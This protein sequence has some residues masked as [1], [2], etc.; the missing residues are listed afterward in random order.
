MY[1]LQSYVS[2]RWESGTGTPRPLLNPATEEQVAETTTEGIDF[3]AALTYARDVGGP[4]LRAL[5]F[6]QRGETLKAMSRAL[7]EHREELIALEALNNGA[8]RGD[9]KF[10]VDGATGTLA[11]YARQGRQLGD[12]RWQICGESEKLS[13]GARFIGQHVRLPRPGVA[14]HVNAFNFPGWGTFEKVAVALLSGMP[15]VSK[16]A[17]ATALTAWRMAQIIVEADILPEGAFSFVAGSTGDLLDHLGPQD[18]VA[19]TGSAQTGAWFRNLPAVREL[20]TRMGI[21]ADSLNAAVLGPDVSVGDEI[22]HT[23]IRNIVKDMTQKTGQK[24]TAIRRVM[25]PDA[26]ADSVAEA[27]AEELAR[28]KVGNPADSSVTMGPVATAQQLQDTRDGIELLS[29]QADIVCG[30]TAPVQGHGSPEGK[31]FFVSPTVL[32]ARNAREATHVHQHEVFGPCTTILPYNGEAQEA[33][34]LVAL[35]QGCLVSS[36]YTNERNWLGDF[37]MGAGPWNGRVQAV[38]KKV[39]DQSLPPGMV[40][41]NQIHG[42]PGRAGGGEELGG[43]RGMEFYTQRVAIQGDLGMLR[44]I[45]QLS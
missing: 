7:H 26:I 21:E 32:K 27:L 42:G 19:F 13:S 15:I 12:T 8:T 11:W 5:T 17:T 10:D 1:R 35:G 38:S 6:A 41:P 20:S 2:G 30:G 33:A 45:F 4:A 40:L 9:A 14:V 3:A 37:L 36:V 29:Q 22:W 39:A 25:V 43:L 28:T 16:P 31:G 18:C 23:F 24:C 34:D 44:K